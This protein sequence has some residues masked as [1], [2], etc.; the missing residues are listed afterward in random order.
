[1]DLSKYKQKRDFDSTTEPKGEIE[2]SKDE[3]IFVVQKH[4]ATHLHYDF[5]LEMDGLL[6]SW[7]IPKGPSMN[8]EEKR[9]AIMVEDHPIDYKD[10]EGTI[11]EGNYGA[12]T[13]IV[14]DTGT[15]TLV[16][17]QHTET[18]ENQLKSGLQGGHL[19][20]ILNGEKLK[21]EFALVR[22]KVL[23]KNA[24]LLIKKDDQYASETD[25]L[26]KN[27]SVLSNLTLEEMEK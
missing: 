20:F 15:Y 16:D 6:K 5:R 2:K 17:K 10:F 18:V 7:A 23:K 14:W 24:W 22:L 3:L 1:M 13:V 11:P 19:S 26:K 8:P 9:L 25:V 4:A 21:G 27:K 12:G